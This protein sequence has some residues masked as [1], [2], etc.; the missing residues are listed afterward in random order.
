MSL[1]GGWGKNIPDRGWKSTGPELGAGMDWLRN[2]EGGVG[3][4]EHRT[5]EREREIEIG[6][7]QG[8][9]KP[10]SRWGVEVWSRGGT[11]SDL[12]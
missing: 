1:A 6:W 2:T 9:R 5:R 12:R 10:W 7:H 11:A 4:S 8:R 3:Q